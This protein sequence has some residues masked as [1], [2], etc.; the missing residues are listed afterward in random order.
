MTTAIRAATLPSDDT[1][2]GDAP[3]LRE[4]GQREVFCGLTGIV[5]KLDFQAL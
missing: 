5:R 1:G 4:R 2:C 3:V